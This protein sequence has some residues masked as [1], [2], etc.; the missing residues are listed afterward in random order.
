MVPARRPVTF[1]NQNYVRK[2][3]Q[4]GQTYFFY[5]TL[6]GEGYRP[7]YGKPRL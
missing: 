3:L 5:G 7:V 2:A 1:F 4:P 6:T